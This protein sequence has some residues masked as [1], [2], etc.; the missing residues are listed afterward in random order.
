MGTEA[1]KN[2]IPLWF[3]EEPHCRREEWMVLK[4]RLVLGREGEACGE[5]RARMG[6]H[7]SA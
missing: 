1:R 7:D 2:D 5:V 6:R 4:R 3:R